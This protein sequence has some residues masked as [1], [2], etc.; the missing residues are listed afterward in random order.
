MLKVQLTAAWYNV[1]Q[2]DR[3]EG[4]EALMRRTRPDLVLT[5]MALPDGTAMDVKRLLQTDRS[6]ADVPVLAIAPRN[7]KAARL[8]A[9]AAGL[10]DVLVQPYN[11]NLLL[12]RIRSLLRTSPGAEELRLR[13]GSQPLG[14]AEAPAIVNPLAPPA[15]VALFALRPDTGIAWRDAL[16]PLTRHRVASHGFDQARAALAGP[17]PDAFVV[18]LGRDGA[19]LNLLADLHA[20]SAAR[21]TVLIA[22]LGLNDADLAAAALDRGADAALLDGFCAEELALRLDNRIARKTR[23]DYLRAPVRKSLLDATR[24]G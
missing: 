19:E 22:V 12:A 7:D 17:L 2:A 16:Q 9:L 18:E 3:L 1:V 8:R 24:T 15:L 4:F 20:R 14:F 6:Q 13:N 23:S 11:D 5:A 21:H 10:D